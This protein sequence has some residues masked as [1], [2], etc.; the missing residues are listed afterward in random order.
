MS[1]LARWTIAPRLWAPGVANV[2]VW[3]Q[4]E[5]QLQVQVDP[6]ELRGQRRVALQVITT[7]G[8]ALWVVAVELRR[9][10]DARHR[11]VHRHAEPAARS[12]AHARRSPR[13]PDLAKVAARGR[14]HRAADCALGDVA[15]VVEDHQPLIG[16][17]VVND[18]GG[19][20][21]RRGEVPRGERRR[22]DA[23]ASRQR[24]PR[25]RPGLAGSR[26]RHHRL[27]AGLLHRAVDRQP[28][29]WR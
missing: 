24:S 19:P 20:H 10:I 2:A 16:D 13:P 12:P 21:A 8:N 25:M 15:N 7:A 4:R 1:V 14:R 23:R 3:G 29:A 17:A 26:L 9:G 22:R 18:G 27:P 6:D 11:R 5:R 28:H